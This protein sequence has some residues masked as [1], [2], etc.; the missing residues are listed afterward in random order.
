MGAFYA[1]AVVATA[2]FFPLPAQAV[3]FE[4]EDWHSQRHRVIIWGR[5]NKGDGDR[6]KTFLNSNLKAGRLISNVAIY[7]PGGDVAAAISMGEQIRKLN[8]ATW[9]PFLKEGTPTCSTGSLLAPTVRTGKDCDCQSACFIVWVGG[10]GRNGD[11]IGVHRPYYGKEYFGNLS[12]EEA[13]K[14]YQEVIEE[15]RRYFAK[16]DVPSWSTSK[17]FSVAS[18][19]MKFLTSDEI[20]QFNN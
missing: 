9:A 2:F 16:M 18:V 6:F 1:L 3:T 5:I 14:A 10:V 8:A 7:S 4:I 11:Y 15:A 17:M 19:D 20:A 12:P 13:A